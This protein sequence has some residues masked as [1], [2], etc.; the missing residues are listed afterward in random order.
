MESD[1]FH[2]NL[3][4]SATSVGLYWNTFRALAERV[5]L[6]AE[7]GAE[8]FPVTEAGRFGLLG[9]A[10][11]DGVGVTREPLARPNRWPCIGEANALK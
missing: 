5:G 10:F 3:I 9:G 1:D 2:L 8:A 6:H 4:N 7:G 11:L